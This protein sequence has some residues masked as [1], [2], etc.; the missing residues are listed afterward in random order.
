[1]QQSFG[2]GGLVA[3]FFMFAKRK[4]NLAEVW[5]PA[6]RPRAGDDFEHC[7]LG[8]HVHR[9]VRRERSKA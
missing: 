5:R 8:C 4:Q 3:A 7:D 1:L 2:K 6:K 9:S